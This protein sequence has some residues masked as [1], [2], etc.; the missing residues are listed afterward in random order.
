MPEVSVTPLA[1]TTGDELLTS[2]A[3]NRFYER[4]RVGDGQPVL[5][6]AEVP[7]PR[8]SP[9]SVGAPLTMQHV[10]AERS[11][12]FGTAAEE[13]VPT[14]ISTITEPTPIIRPRIVRPVPQ[15]VRGQ[16]GERDAHDLDQ[17]DRSPLSRVGDARRTRSGRR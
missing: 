8:N 9:P 4:V 11:I 12:W 5:A 6:L 14:A 3:W 1:F 2:G 7:P 15:L 16:P 13:P 17:Q 10:G